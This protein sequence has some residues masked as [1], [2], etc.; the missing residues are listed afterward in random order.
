MYKYEDPNFL[1]YPVL[2]LFL[3]ILSYAEDKN[4]Y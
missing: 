3:M 2:L 4:H 1:D